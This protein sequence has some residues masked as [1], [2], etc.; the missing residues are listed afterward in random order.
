MMPFGIFQTK[1]LYVARS[2]DFET[3]KAFDTNCPVDHVPKARPANHEDD[4]LQFQI[5][6]ITSMEEWDL[7]THGFCILKA[8]T[9]SQTNSI[10]MDQEAYAQRITRE[11]AGTSAGAISGVYQN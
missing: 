3:E 8:Q 4:T 2:T 9:S 7:N 10:F 5:R 1:I 11:N 6:N